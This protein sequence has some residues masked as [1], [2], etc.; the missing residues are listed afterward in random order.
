[1]IFNSTNL[2]NKLIINFANIT[3]Q[4]DDKKNVVNDFSRITTTINSITMIKFFEIICKNIFKCL[5][6]A[7]F[8]KNFFLN[9]MSTYFE[10]VKINDDNT[11]YLHCFL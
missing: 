9:S 5:L 8:F 11:L 7:K 10:I 6:I 3:Y 4:I 2:R 1:M